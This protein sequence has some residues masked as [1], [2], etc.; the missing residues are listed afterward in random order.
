MKPDYAHKETDKQL[1]L[2]EQR[3]SKIYEQAAGE[4]AETVKTYFEQFDKRDAAMLEK[5]EKSEI[6]E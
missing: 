6:T 1:A 3:I 5:L 4:L 2:L